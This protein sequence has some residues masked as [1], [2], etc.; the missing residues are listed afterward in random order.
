MCTRLGFGSLFLP[1]SGE[2]IGYWR[3]R[4]WLRLLSF[5]VEGG[6]FGCFRPALRSQRWIDRFGW[7]EPIGD[8]WWPV[9]GAVY[10]LSAVKRVRG[11]RFVGLARTKNAKPRAAPAVATNSTRK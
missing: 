5:E 1:R 4:D 9:L 10:F 2:F 8:R 3:L 6:H 11:M 7:I